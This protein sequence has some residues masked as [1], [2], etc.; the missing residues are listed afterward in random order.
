MQGE[1][2]DRQRIADLGHTVAGGGGERIHKRTVDAKLPARAPRRFRRAGDDVPKA[3]GGQATK[4]PGG[5]LTVR[6][7]RTRE[8]VERGID[9]VVARGQHNAQVEVVR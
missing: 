1:R 8:P 9:A 4:T 5:Y 6:Q 7:A 3:G 2:Q